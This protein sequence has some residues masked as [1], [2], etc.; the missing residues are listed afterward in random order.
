MTDNENTNSENTGSGSGDNNDR[1]VEDSQTS[2]G[3]G[4]DFNLETTIADAKR[5]ITD[6]VG[7]YREMPKSGGFEAPVLFVLAAAVALAVI[8]TALSF[9]GA[10]QLGGMGVGILSLIVIPIVS[11]I[12]SFIIAAIVFVI[13][14]LLGSD[15]NYET[16]YRCI[17][18]AAAIWPIVGVVNL[19]PYVGTI[20]GIVWG[21]Y[22]MV[23]AS[24][25]V[26]GRQRDAVY[27]VFGILGAILLFSNLS[28]E[29]AARRLQARFG[30]IEEM[31]PEEAGQ[32]LGEFLRGVQQELPEREEEE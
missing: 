16:A 17:A 12:G 5:V 18:Y 29:W 22:L 19:I 27:L 1:G 10:G 25:E 15:E 9:L 6:P 26:H 24:T 20:V 3:L 2:P 7:F 31:S 4:R 28:A 21:M 11:V 14:K 30:N 13:W 23:V 8:A 32:A